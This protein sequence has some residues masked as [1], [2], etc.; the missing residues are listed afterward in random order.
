M[1]NVY[2]CTILQCELNGNC[3][4]K[5]VIYATTKFLKSCKHEL[6][7]KMQNLFDERQN[8]AQVKFFLQQSTLSYD[9]ITTTVCI[10]KQSIIRN[11]IGQKYDLFTFLMR[12]SRYISRKYKSSS[13]SSQRTSV[14]L[15]VSHFIISHRI[16]KNVKGNWKLLTKVSRHKSRFESRSQLVFRHSLFATK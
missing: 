12:E 16:Y 11:R 13:S 6:Q 7:T 2:F 15:L 5:V 9:N 10:Q 1:R 3:L 4:S 14:F 8:G